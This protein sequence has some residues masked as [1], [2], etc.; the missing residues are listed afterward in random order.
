MEKDFWL[1]RWER[2]ETG[3][4]QNEV[5]PYL[6]QHWQ[7]LHLARDSVVFVPL[8]GKSRDM[9]WLR[10]QGHRVLGV[11]LSAIAVQAFFNL[12]GISRTIPMTG[13][14]LPLISFGS[15]ALVATLAAAGI[16]VSVS[17]F[18]LQPAPQAEAKPQ[19]RR[20]DYAAPPARSEEAA[21]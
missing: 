14:P 15:S 7:E 10:K 5:N 8:C 17:R 4:H 3:F 9:L 13:I 16:L 1:E 19:A 11:E 2:K 6:R 12:G 20:R 18:G 21:P